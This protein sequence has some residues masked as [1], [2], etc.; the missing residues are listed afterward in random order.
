MEKKELNLVK[1]YFSR[2]YNLGKLITKD[3]FQKLQLDLQAKALDRDSKDF[4]KFR[5]LSLGF[6]T[7]LRDRGLILDKSKKLESLK[8]LIDNIIPS[9]FEEKWVRKK[10]GKDDDMEI[11]F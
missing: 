3:N 6:D 8:K 7:A 2:G 5:A 11:D 4:Q 10:K 1:K 9:V